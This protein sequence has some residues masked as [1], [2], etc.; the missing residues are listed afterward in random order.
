M[1]RSREAAGKLPLGVGTTQ[2][3]PKPRRQLG[4]DTMT[5]EHKENHL[6]TER[7]GASSSS[8]NSSNENSPSS[9][10]DKDKKEKGTV[11][12][13]G[14]KNNNQ[15]ERAETP[16]GDKK[17]ASP[18]SSD[19]TASDS[20]RPNAQ[21]D[22][23][24]FFAD[25]LSK[26]A[27]GIDR[28]LAQ[29]DRASAVDDS[30][31]NMNDGGSSASDSFLLQTLWEDYP[32]RCA[33]FV[34]SLR[35]WLAL[36]PP[37]FEKVFVTVLDWA[38]PPFSLQ[39]KLP[40][41][42]VAGLHLVELLWSRCAGD[43]LS[44]ML[45]YASEDVERDW[46]MLE[47]LS[48]KH[49]ISRTRRSSSANGSTDNSS[50]GGGGSGRGQLP[51]D[52]L[53]R[54]IAQT[55]TM[56]ASVL[57]FAVRKKPALITHLF[58][59]RPPFCAWLFIDLSL[60]NAGVAREILAMLAE[61]LGQP[62]QDKASRLIMLLT[63]EPMLE[64]LDFQRLADRD[65][66]WTAAFNDVVTKQL[67]KTVEQ[68]AKTEELKAAALS[69]MLTIL[70]RAP[71][72][73][74]EANY[75]SFFS[76]RVLRHLSEPRKVTHSLEIILRSLRSQRFARPPVAWDAFEMY[77]PLETRFREGLGPLSRISALNRR[78]LES[79]YTEVFER[80]KSKA[81]ASLGGSSSYGVLTSS[82]NMP[83]PAAALA[84]AG[85]GSTFAAAA[86][87]NSTSPS[88]PEPP[89]LAGVSLGTARFSISSRDVAAT[90]IGSLVSTGSHLSLSSIGSGASHVSGA[91]FGTAP[92]L[93][94]AHQHGFP[95]LPKNLAVC[96][97]ILLQLAA[98]DVTILLDKAVPFVT[99]L[100]DD[101]NKCPHVAANRAIVGIRT[102]WDVLG[103]STS[104]FRE[105]AFCL[106][107][108][109]FEAHRAS[110]KDVHK[111]TV[112]KFAQ[113]FGSL[114]AALGVGVMGQAEHSL[115]PT[116][117]WDGTTGVGGAGPRGLRDP[118][119]DTRG[120][121]FAWADAG[122]G[123]VLDAFSFTT[124]GLVLELQQLQM[125][126]D[127]FEGG[128][129]IAFRA[130]N[131]SDKYGAELQ[132]AQTLRTRA[133]LFKK[134]VNPALDVF[135]EFLY[136]LPLLSCSPVAEGQN[137]AEAPLPD[138][139]LL[140]H[141]DW[142]IATAVSHALQRIVGSALNDTI[143]I[144]VLLKLVRETSNAVSRFGKCT[145]AIL[146]YVRQMAL[147]LRLWSHLRLRQ[148]KAQS[149]DGQETALPDPDDAGGEPLLTLSIALLVFPCASVRMHVQEIIDA[150]Q[151]LWP[152]FGPACMRITGVLRAHPPF[153]YQCAAKTSCCCGAVSSEADISRRRTADD[154]QPVKRFEPHPPASP[155]PPLTGS[156]RQRQHERSSTA[157]GSM[158][159]SPLSLDALSKTFAMSPTKPSLDT[160]ESFTLPA[161][162]PAPASNIAHTVTSASTGALAR[163][164]LVRTPSARPDTLIKGS[165]CSF[166][167]A[168]SY[169]KAR[170][171]PLVSRDELF[172]WY[173]GTG[174]V[175]SDTDPK[176]ANGRSDQWADE[177]V[178]VARELVRFVEL[179]GLL[180]S[181]S[182]VLLDWLSRLPGF[183]VE[184]EQISYFETVLRKSAVTFVLGS[185]GSS[186][187]LP[188]SP[189]VLEPEAAAWPGE[190]EGEVETLLYDLWD[191]AARIRPVSPEQSALRRIVLDLAG[192]S[193]HPRCVS[194]V[195]ALCLSWRQTRLTAA[196]S[197]SRS[198]PSEERS[199]FGKFRRHRGSDHAISQLASF[200]EADVAS[201]EQICCAALRILLESVAQQPQQQKTTSGFPGWELTLRKIFEFMSAIAQAERL[202]NSGWT[203]TLE[204][205]KLALQAARTLRSILRRE[206]EVP[207]L[208]Q[209]ADQI[210]L[211]AERRRVWT[212]MQSIVG[213]DDVKLFSIQRKA[214]PRAQGHENGGSHA[215]FQSQTPG[216][217][218]RS[219]VQADRQVLS[220][221]NFKALRELATDVGLQM[222]H[223]GPTSLGTVAP[224]PDEMLWS[225]FYYDG[226]R[227]R[228][229]SDASPLLRNYLVAHWHVGDVEAAGGGTFRPFVE[230]W[231][232][233]LQNLPR[234]Q[235][236]ADA[237]FA[238]FADAVDVWLFRG[239]ERNMVRPLEPS[240]MAL[241]AL[242]ALVQA[243]SHA[244]AEVRAR[245]FGL[246]DV[247]ERSDSW[248][249]LSTGNLDGSSTPFELHSASLLGQQTW[250]SDSRTIEQTATQAS[251]ILAD[252]CPGLGPSVLSILCK[253]LP[254]LESAGLGPRTVQACLAFAQS[255]STRAVAHAGGLSGESVSVDSP[256]QFVRN[257]KS[258]SNSARG[259]QRGPEATELAGVAAESASGS[260]RM[261]HGTMELQMR[262]SVQKDIRRAQKTHFNLEELW[263]CVR[264]LVRDEQRN[265]LD[266]TLP[267]WRALCDH[268]APTVVDFL[269][270]RIVENSAA[271][272]EMKQL[273][274]ATF[275]L[276][277]IAPEIFA[278][279]PSIIVNSLVL[280]VL[281]RVRV[282]SIARGLYA[283]SAASP[284]SR[285][286]R[287][288]QSWIKLALT[289]DAD[290]CG[291]NSHKEGLKEEMRSLLRTQASALKALSLCAAGARK[292]CAMA[293]P[294]MITYGL[295]STLGLHTSSPR[296]RYG[297][298]GECIAMLLRSLSHERLVRQASQRTSSD[299]SL[300]MV[301]PSQLLGPS[302]ARLVELAR[303]DPSSYTDQVLEEVVSSMAEL[304]T[305]C[306]PDGDLLHLWC[307]CL[308]LNGLGLYQQQMRWKPELMHRCLAVYAKLRAKIE[309]PLYLVRGFAE[310]DESV[311]WRIEILA[312]LRIAHQAMHNEAF[313]LV[314]IALLCLGRLDLRHMSA[315]LCKF[316]LNFYASVAHSK[317]AEDLCLD[318]LLSALPEELDAEDLDVDALRC[319]TQDRLT[320]QLLLCDARAEDELSEEYE[321][322]EDGDDPSALLSLCIRLF[323]CGVLRVDLVCSWF[324]VL[325]TGALAPGAFV[326]DAV[327]HLDLPV[328]M[329]EALHEFI[330]RPT[331]EE[332]LQN[333]CLAA[334]DFFGAVE[335]A[336]AL[337]RCCTRQIQVLEDENASGLPV[338]AERYLLA[339]YRVISCVV[340][341]SSP[342]LQFF[343]PI[344]RKATL[345]ESEQGAGVMSEAVE[346]LLKAAHKASGGSSLPGQ[347]ASPRSPLRAFG[348]QTAWGGDSTT[349]PSVSAEIRCGEALALM[350]DLIRVDACD[351][352]D[353]LSPFMEGSRS[354][355]TTPR[356]RRRVDAPPQLNVVRSRD[357]DASEDE[358]K[359]PSSGDGSEPWTGGSSPSLGR[360]L[361]GGGGGGD[362]EPT[363]GTTVKTGISE[364]L[365]P[366]SRG[367]GAT[368]TALDEF[369]IGGVASFE[370]SKRGLE[371]GNGGARRSSS[372]RHL[373]RMLGVASDSED[374]DHEDDNDDDSAFG[375]DGCES[376]SDGEG[377]D[378]HH[379]EGTIAWGGTRRHGRAAGTIRLV[380]YRSMEDGTTAEQQSAVMRRSFLEELLANESNHKQ[381]E[382]FIVQQP[383]IDTSWLEFAL[384]VI[385]FKRNPMTE[386][387]ESVFN[388]FLV[389]DGLDT[390]DVPDAVRERVEQAIEAK[391]GVDK[392]L[393]DEG[394][395]LALDYLDKNFLGRYLR[396]SQYCEA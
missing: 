381:I 261:A 268:H 225:W 272:G 312:L 79:I 297:A 91:S 388:Q 320:A 234:S 352:E 151:H 186:Q 351:L 86:A 90:S 296:H 27:A 255:A 299:P 275:F 14:S 190:M 242:L 233:E 283:S 22:G 45:R 114:Q 191:A 318:L 128:R 52:V 258:R 285:R 47:D 80:S 95:L 63:L 152:H 155:P 228:A 387:A 336:L 1:S 49:I 126:N 69:V 328:K 304:L 325:A 241:V 75:A 229:C 16:S 334:M 182:Q 302:P 341:A 142:F 111:L 123:H 82:S 65:P 390:I 216:S 232:V 33:F 313:A 243:A 41:V 308:L 307:Q 157:D 326:D 315:S 4:I 127:L 188:R 246:L 212:L 217:G 172:M 176:T 46:S 269:L 288:L 107:H 215:S 322:T 62:K 376:G 58:N 50:S 287:V 251:I 156:T 170:D 223:L 19:V 374:N 108:G 286:P 396:S 138:V 204:Y 294:Q 337:A 110:L 340:T 208:M 266:L 391:E 32:R 379:D 235:S 289:Q 377:N 35:A 96:K 72:A 171:A 347:G 311:A 218:A 137:P 37:L 323:H 248:A 173:K 39:T 169:I 148:S 389:L 141:A 159:G 98:H 210:W 359:L 76:R 203:V 211:R 178:K 345:L 200:A 60:S 362:F 330:F 13:T 109:Q 239:P 354:P 136:A 280:G 386:T 73:F 112:R 53:H 231:F 147:L 183:Q 327:G 70:A 3:A 118:V 12:A 256:R 106:H 245:A 94:S 146:T 44:H 83:P 38:Q 227:P 55:Q 392:G 350:S 309:G 262:Q 303:L 74:H 25:F 378:S 276:T 10:A 122:R 371:A 298:G 40:G 163:P 385:D 316:F 101:L 249:A 194:R 265:A 48:L 356:W 162:P 64:N 364:D 370:T 301:L 290:P 198:Q 305:L 135:R 89:S 267:L 331:D 321:G 59:L 87:P 209:R 113:M 78:A 93:S 319:K 68:L 263:E 274:I 270:A 382:T 247:V 252:R 24:F 365:E 357:P 160:R 125:H 71:L 116:L 67:F 383:A 133:A 207:M 335:F 342:C 310:V 372:A 129:E 196:S 149:A 132:I 145:R 139:T 103:P 117:L 273:E 34:G 7:N 144:R 369:E 150:M 51:R 329:R 97:H 373:S 358:L 339:V 338:D 28:K 278:A 81:F 221:N 185:A 395:K 177:L 375:K 271:Q 121:P 31:G 214:S 29:L 380:R 195:V 219:I 175:T 143:R 394:L 88:S 153:G 240:A 222:L 281:Y 30:S 213:F 119:G 6:I 8:T 393:F 291:Y 220:E 355:V 105:T 158:R 192:K 23:W 164:P 85:S 332:C 100:P 5:L 120:Y 20:G 349:G 259:L 187:S 11:D 257:R 284:T 324:P 61:Q 237:I 180:H 306:S 346:D 264:T 15:S 226:D 293:F 206:M 384:A 115:V 279:S 56:W 130:R 277:S 244:S 193:M 202:R 363:T 199:K 54:V 36:P 92:S 131:L 134:R 140:L 66:A 348:V 238:S 260:K 205:T 361:G 317:R 292:D 21:V 368:S 295:C 282:E 343:I 167:G 300:A 165:T 314:E 124:N 253:R 184:A 179:R 224:R 104:V 236:R 18:V 201:V 161:P 197:P 353:T 2:I 168:F 17:P 254:V 154:V 230:R 366:R 367:I 174:V 360:G 333:A 26:F 42:K 189:L 250:A 9:D 84:F 102:L 166:E 77:N 344:V 99:Q 57:G 181:A 43:L